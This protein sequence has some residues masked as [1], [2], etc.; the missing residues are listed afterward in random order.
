MTY[1]I[2]DVDKELEAI[3]SKVQQLQDS[4][5][6]ML[7]SVINYTATS[8]KQEKVTVE[9]SF[10]MTIFPLK[11]LKDIEDLERRFLAN[12]NLRKSLVSGVNFYSRFIDWKMLLK[13]VSICLRLL[14]YRTLVAMELEIPAVA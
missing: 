5:D 1:L 11:T 4:V 9:E 14:S 12:P 3:K 8:I 2:L 13:I 10:D 6:F 7:P